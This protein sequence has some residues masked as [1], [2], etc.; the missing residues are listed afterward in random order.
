MP[1]R[2][3]LFVIFGSNLGPDTLTQATSFP[4]P[5]SDGLV[6]TRIRI[7]AGTYTGFAYILYTS[8]A[9]VGA[10]LPSGTPEGSATLTLN[11][12]N[13]TSN[14]VVVKVVRSAFG[15][16][17][18]NQGGRGPA[19]LQN[20]V[21]ATQ[22]PVNTV[23][24]SATPGQSVILW[25]TGLGPVTGDES[26]GPLPGT[27][28]TVDSVLVGGQPATVR[29]AGRTGCCAA[30]D[31][32]VFDVPANVAGCYVPVV[33][34]TGGIPSN[35]GTIAVSRSGGACD[36]PLSFRAADLAAAQ[37]T[38][39]VHVGTVQLWQQLAPGAQFGTDS[40]NASFISYPTQ[41]L[42]TTAVTVNP[43]VGTCYYTQTPV[44]ADPSALPHGTMLDAGIN[45]QANGQGINLNAPWVSP[46]TYTGSM[47][48]QLLPAGSY[49]VTSDGGGDIGSVRG[50][51]TVAA[52]AQ[53]TNAADY[54]SFVN[55]GQ[56]LAFRWA[57]GGSGY[58]TIGI[59]FVG[60]TLSESVVCNV[61]ASAGSFTIP[62]W[63]S[64]TIPQGTAQVSLSSYA[65]PAPFSTTGLDSGTFTAG[66]RTAL[67]VQFRT[68]AN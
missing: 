37:R 9:Q 5:G 51:L 13:L 59:D 55:V 17:T 42:T 14:P 29:F 41:T 2:G 57:G 23:F 3:S 53:W 58:V 4:L 43:P 22:Q 56:P 18:L 7:D 33:V 66:S 39:R 28:S 38:G 1:A 32:I 35:A 45:F 47:S 31:E 26:A 46:G 24:N 67:T 54:Q 11:Y 65:A 12:N 6:G 40:L 49:F 60:V 15:M 50:S 34:M 20:F 68:P 44:T 10:I 36:D 61:A 19:V 16:F 27:L 30:V 25:G 21:S 8:K 63:L 52:P 48:Q 62:A 64:G